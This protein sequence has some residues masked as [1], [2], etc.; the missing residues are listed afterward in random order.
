M[1]LMELLEQGKKATRDGLG[2]DYIYTDD[3][4]G[5]FAFDY[6]EPTEMYNIGLSDLTRNDWY[7]YEEYKTNFE[8]EE[9][10]HDCYV[11]E[12][13]NDITLI[14][15][16]AHCNYESY[17]KNFNAF[18]NKELAKF[19]QKKQLLERKLMVFSYLNGTS[20]IDWNKTTCKYY[21]YSSYISGVTKIESRYATWSQELNNVFFSN[22]EICDKA[23]ELY[24]DEIKEVMRMKIELGF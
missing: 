12:K 7:E 19:I 15:C 3:V 22:E 13:Y 21:I 23:I 6:N 5:T 17:I 2:F 20:E 1:K 10:K 24:E 18:P 11:I 9:G 4:N 14:P 16:L 8:F